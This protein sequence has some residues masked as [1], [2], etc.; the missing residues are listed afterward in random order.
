ML[1]KG[2][3]HHDYVIQVHQTV[4]LL[5]SRQHHV[6]ETLKGSWGIT[7]SEGHDLE[8]KKPIRCA[9]SCLLTIH[10]LDFHL[11]VTAD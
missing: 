2:P 3:T 10:L 5:Q 1:L 9:K 8:L 11:P 6:H 7:E 4:G